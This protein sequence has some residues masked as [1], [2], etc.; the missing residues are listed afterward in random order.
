MCGLLIIIKELMIVNEIVD[1]L[2]I[3]CGN[4]SMGIKEL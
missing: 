4:V 3:L 2:S 1:I